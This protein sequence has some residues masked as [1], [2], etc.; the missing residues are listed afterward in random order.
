MSKKYKI[1][2]YGNEYILK[3]VINLMW[4]FPI[5]VTVNES[6]GPSGDLLGPV[7]FSSVEK[8]KKYFKEVYE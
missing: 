5:W 3:R 6:Q 4:I 1:E 7:E 2:K 8:A